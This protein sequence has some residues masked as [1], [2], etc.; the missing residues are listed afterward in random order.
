MYEDVDESPYVYG[1][2]CDLVEG[3]HPAI[4]GANT[5]NLPKI[6]GIIAEAFAL[7]ALPVDHEVRRRMINIVA[8][9]Q[10]KE[11]KLIPNSFQSERGLRF[12]SQNL[13]YCVHVERVTFYSK[14]PLMISFARALLIPF[15]AT[16]DT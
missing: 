10:V 16:Y 1:Y 5:A 15:V 14:A 12:S 3:N 9:V 6:V 2:L 13:L 8:Q 7:D 4:L 11:M